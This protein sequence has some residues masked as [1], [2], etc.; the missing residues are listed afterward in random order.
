M[1]VAKTVHVSCGSSSENFVISFK[2][3]IFMQQMMLNN[4]VRY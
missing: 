3:K 4:V 1:N 2:C